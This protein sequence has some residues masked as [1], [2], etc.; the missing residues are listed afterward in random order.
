[1]FYLSGRKIKINSVK[2]CEK[3]TSI[4]EIQKHG[5]L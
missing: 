1:M 2:F 5:L 4:V 3:I